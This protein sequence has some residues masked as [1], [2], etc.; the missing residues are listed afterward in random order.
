M[1][2]RSICP[3]GGTLS[4][5]S[6]KWKPVLL[7]MISNEINRFNQIEKAVTG[8]S[9]KVL[10]TQLRSLEKYG[11]IARS[12]YK[13]KHPQVVVYN[14]TTRGYTLLELMDTIFDWGANNLLEEPH[15]SHVQA[16]RK[17]LQ[18]N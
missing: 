3:V 17:K 5:I 16:V 13:K 7:F 1:N 8:I 6:G 2:Q 18:R 9:K 15:R 14:L 11:L 4:L 10:T 12:V